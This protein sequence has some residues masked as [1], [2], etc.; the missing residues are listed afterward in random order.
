[1]T[2][3]VQEANASIVAIS[4]N[5]EDVSKGTNEIANSAGQ[6]SDR[7][8]LMS[9]NIESVSESSGHTEQGASDVQTTSLELARLASALEKTVAQFA[10]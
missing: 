6:A 5:L 8:S 9:K 3:Q 2:R 4:R 10:L 1:V 7:A